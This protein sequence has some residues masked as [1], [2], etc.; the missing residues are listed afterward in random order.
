M[1]R[2]QL[3]DF[4]QDHLFWAFDA[5]SPLVAPVFTPLFGFSRITSPKINVTVES[6]KDGTYL[7]PRH[8]VTG[9]EVGSITFERA[10][11]LIDSDFYDWITYAIYGQK[12]TGEDALSA[13]VAGALGND[14]TAFL[15]PGVRRNIVV[16]HFTRI[17][18]GVPGAIQSAL[19]AVG[20]ATGSTAGTNGVVGI[21]P[22]EFAAR[23][24]ARA[25]LLH[26]CIPLSY[27]A[28]SDFDA[29]SGQI[30]L[31]SL[32]V[33]PEYIEEFSLGLKP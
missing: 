23:V 12:P 16:I 21:G 31:M 14:G 27:Q 6:F 3:T 32:E 29:R 17:N 5:S 30:S 18:P 22:F 33:L 24:P 9:A 8:V 25:W 15:A 1:P 28:G 11:S 20:A 2:P 4:L 19:S 10:A 13:A 7:Y 26:A